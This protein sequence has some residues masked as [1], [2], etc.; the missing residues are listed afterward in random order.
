[1]DPCEK[2]VQDAG[3]ALTAQE[4]ANITLSAQVGGASLSRVPFPRFECCAITSSQLATNPPAHLYLFSI[5][6]NGRCCVVTVLRS[7]KVNPP[8]P[9]SLQHA[10]RL[11]AFDKLHLVLGV[12]PL[13]PPGTYRKREPPAPSADDAANT[14]SEAKKPRKE[15]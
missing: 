2:G 7:S 3:A 9:S 4:R 6:F 12:E 10:L 11:I 15:D 14:E 5:A 8:P 13:P 1:M